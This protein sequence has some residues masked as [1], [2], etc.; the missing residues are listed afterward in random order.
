MEID[1]KNLH[2]LEVR[3]L[4][5]VALGEP[6]TAGRI[7]DEL[8]YKVGGQCNQA[9]S[10][11][12][13]KGYLVEKSRESRVSYELTEF[14]REQAE[15]GTP[16]QRIFTFIKAEGPHALPEIASALGLE[17]SEVGSAFGQ[18]SKA[19][20]AK[21][22]D[23]NKAQS[24]TDELSGEFLL[25]ANLLQKGLQGDLDESALDAD[26]KKAMGKIA[27]KRGAA[28]SPFKVIEREDIVY[29]LTEEGSQA[30]EAVLK[31]NITGEEL[32][33]LTP[34]RCLPPEA[35]KKVISDPTV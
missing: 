24:T 19:R 22:N 15:K 23:E 5:H 9:F 14:G 7:V 31:A 1:V 2:P 11:L 4:R 20:C 33:S 13:A 28:S 27:K 32:G 34:Q 12:S 8:D 21:M 18:L 6:I 16:A 25:T 30:K 10:W 35:G 17:K 26:E 3:L 29:E